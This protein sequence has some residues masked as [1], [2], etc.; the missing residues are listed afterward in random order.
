MAEEQDESQK[1]EEPSQKRLDDAHKK[2]DVPRSQE[3]RHWFALVSGAIV[4][5]SV[6]A[7]TGGGMTGTLEAFIRNAHQIPMDGAGV[8]RALE[9]VFIR[10]FLILLLPLGL[11]LAGSLAGSFIQHKPVFTGERLKPKLSK[12]SP[13]AGVKRL[14][15]KNSLMEFSK[16][17]AKFLIV[18]GVGV[19]I[20]WPDRDMLPEFVL[21]PT[22]E[23]LAVTH[24]V[25]IRLFAG[26]VA[27]MTAIAFIDM[28]FQRMQH[29]KKLRMTKQEVKDENKQLEGDP[30][31]KARIRQLRQERSRQ[32][33]AQAVPGA[34]VVIMNPTHYAVALKYRH[35]EMDVPMLLAKGVD[36]LALRIRDIAKDHDIPVVEN[37][38][39]ARA[40][41]ATVEVDQ[42]IPPKHY[43][44]VAEVISY[45]L[46]LKRRR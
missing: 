23:M 30:H 34:D 1:T 46:K 44:A 31:V 3:L 13:L 5:S 42:E 36:H 15:S 25:V 7:W 21:M 43:K 26:V 29:T 19:W 10:V 6:A 32:R 45:V 35:G 12:I 8:G 27:V 38:P 41:Y 14:F 11:I 28:V 20:I 22:R 39:L 18:G 16:T 33:V 37:P 24:D 40:L 9:G 4:L 2:G 17:I